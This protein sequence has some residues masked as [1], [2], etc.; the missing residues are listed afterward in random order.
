MLI[1]IKRK[2]A[3]TQRFILNTEITEQTKCF[4]CSEKLSDLASLYY[5]KTEYLFSQPIDIELLAILYNNNPAILKI[6]FTLLVIIRIDI[7]NTS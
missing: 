7:D 2:D 3:K 6:L 1:H 4:L 5:K